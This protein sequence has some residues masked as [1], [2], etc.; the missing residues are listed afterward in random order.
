MTTSTDPAR[1]VT[2]RKP[3]PESN[4]VPALVRKIDLGNQ[5]W[6]TAHRSGW[7]YALGAL[8]ELHVPGGVLLEG[9]VEKKFAW[10]HDPGDRN[11]DPRP[12]TKPW[13]GFWH[14][15]PHVP[16][17]FNAACHAPADILDSWLWQASVPYC[18]GLFTLSAHLR[19]WLEPRVPVKVRDLRHPTG[20]ATI[21]FS[22][23]RYLSS[24]RR[25]IV[26]VGWWLRCERSLSELDVPSLDKAVL[27]P[28][29]GPANGAPPA[30][31]ADYGKLT[32]VTQIPYLP[33]PDYDVLLSENIVFL[34]LYDSSANNTII[35]CII[36]STPVLVNPLPA[37][38][39][40]LGA[41]YPFYFTDL[42][43]ASRKAEQPRL[44]LAAHQYLRDAP[45]RHR[46]TTDAFRR[47]FAA[48]DIY[49]EL[50]P[51]RAEPAVLRRISP[52]NRPSP[53]LPT[54]TA[55]R[56]RLSPP[57]DPGWPTVTIFTSVYAGDDDIAEFLVDIRG[58]TVFDECELLLFDIHS[59]HRDPDAVRRTI[60]HF[61]REHRNIRFLPVDTDP[62][63]Y[64]IW[65]RAIEMSR[66]PLLTNANLDDRKAP[67]ALEHH[68]AALRQHR[69]LD[70]V[71]AE[72]LATD[73]PFQ[74][75]SA[76]SATDTYFTDMDAGPHRPSWSLTRRGDGAPVTLVEF[77]LDDLFRYGE[78]GQPVDSRNVPHCMPMWRASLHKRFG[79]LD[80]GRYGP[81]ADW[82]FWIRCA[83]GGARLGLLRRSLGLYYVNP[84]SHNR[85]FAKDAIKDRILASY[86][87]R[88]HA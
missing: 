22:P 61:Q 58:Q 10:G 29:P 49:R 44:V 56:P 88:W 28:F 75:W 19:R 39:E 86:G 7:A 71:C 15:P 14:N 2:P 17:A 70:L 82:A 18:R 16:D 83:S 67:D 50:P 73:V 79:M 5:W 57:S 21:T 36:R 9:F 76:N 53:M 62:G 80:P 65:N 42:Q 30:G 24:P 41:A 60:Q 77:G 52:P 45:I 20:P 64:Q 12:H 33:D 66:G 25:R 72:I 32:G 13:I 78:A 26:Q 51:P 31:W 8:D 69:Q 34:D 63:L 40:Y 35:E 48:S 84:S 3:P 55:P 37:V 11:N 47:E 54:T 38:V 59:S 87:A 85:R 81:L 1:T 4:G 74:T 68:L 27:V 23:Q 43:E 6:P 46:L